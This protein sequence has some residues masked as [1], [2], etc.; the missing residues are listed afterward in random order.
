LTPGTTASAVSFTVPLTREFTVCPKTDA[1]ANRHNAI[2]MN[3]NLFMGGSS[4]GM[5]SQMLNKETAEH[6]C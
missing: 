3:G 4:K 6:V 5:F 2:A 1:A